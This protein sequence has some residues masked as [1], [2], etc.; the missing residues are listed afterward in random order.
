MRIKRA[1][2]ALLR[3]P[4]PYQKSKRKPKKER[5]TAQRNLSCV[6]SGGEKGV[7]CRKKEELWSPKQELCKDKKG[8]F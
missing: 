3:L 5:K 1:G 7:L 8:D 2:A 6:V 4:P